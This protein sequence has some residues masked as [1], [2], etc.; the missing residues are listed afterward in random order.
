MV[1]AG[2]TV[3]T[4]ADGAVLIAYNWP[5]N[6]DRYGRVETFINTF[7]PRIAEFAQPPHHLK[8]RE[9][10]LRATLAGWT[11]LESAE[12][13]LNSNREKAVAEERSQF[14]S[15]LAERGEP[16]LLLVAQKAVEFLQRWLHN[17]YRGDREAE[18]ISTA[19]APPV[20]F[21]VT[22]GGEP[23]RASCPS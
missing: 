15:S 19:V 16:Q 21:D 20:G 8:W 1:P 23:D 2:Q 22:S 13:W 18:Q 5:K 3:E 6:T 11:R 7:F 10:N 4:I 14:K 12:A 17:L 9:V